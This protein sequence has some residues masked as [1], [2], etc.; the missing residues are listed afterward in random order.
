[1]DEI[2]SE[3]NYLVAGVILMIYYDGYASLNRQAFEAQSASVLRAL[4]TADESIVDDVYIENTFTS[5]CPP[6]YPCALITFFTRSTSQAISKY[7]FPL[8]EG[9][10]TN[11]ITPDPVAW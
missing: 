1:M 8:F 7:H 5:M 9:S 11:V 2:E 6:D 4:E 10:C 3:V